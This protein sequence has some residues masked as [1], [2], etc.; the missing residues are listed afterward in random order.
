MNQ[1]FIVILSRLWC[2]FSNQMQ[3]WKWAKFQRMVWKHWW[4]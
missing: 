3:K 1:H 2:V 4:T